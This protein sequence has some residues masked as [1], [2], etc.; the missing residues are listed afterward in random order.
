MVIGMS[1]WMCLLLGLIAAG[2]DWSAA[3]PNALRD[4]IAAI[5][6]LASGL[7]WMDILGVAGWELGI[8]RGLSHDW[9]VIWSMAA[10]VPTG[11]WI[12]AM[13]PRIRCLGRFAQ[14]ELRRGGAG[15]ANATGK[16]NT[17]LLS[18]TIAVCVAT[19]LLAPSA[20]TRIVAGIQGAAIAGATGVG[21]AIASFFG[22]G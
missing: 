6:Y 12:G 16:I 3:G 22:W 10:I 5:G 4:R 17:Y 15:A 20:F 9:Q 1:M 2:I 11:F 7:G 18:W 14:L 19:P 13:L 8:Y 21:G